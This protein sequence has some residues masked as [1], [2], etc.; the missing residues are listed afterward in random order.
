MHSMVFPLHLIA[1]LS[2]SIGCYAISSSEILSAHRYTE[3]YLPLTKSGS[4]S[5]W[6]DYVS[7]PSD[8][9]VATGLDTLDSR[10]KR[11]FLSR[12]S[13]SGS[14]FSHTTSCGSIQTGSSWKI[15]GTTD[16]LDSGSM[17]SDFCDCTSTP[18]CSISS[19]V[20]SSAFASTAEGSSPSKSATVTSLF[21]AVNASSVSQSAQIPS[22][23]T[24]SEAGASNSQSILTSSSKITRAKTTT[25]T[26]SSQYTQP[27][28]CTNTSQN[29]QWNITGYDLGCDESAN[30]VFLLP[31][32]SGTVS[33]ANVTEGFCNFE[34][35]M[36]SDEGPQ[37]RVYTFSHLNC[38][39]DEDSPLYVTEPGTTGCGGFTG[40]YYS[41]N[42]TLYNDD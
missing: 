33:C 5:I 10:V 36:N 12:N 40:L 24:V 3:T 39:Y 27:A 8:S 2:S 37:Y 15:S 31:S 29:S 23:I 11:H 14:Q 6:P 32:C 7:L 34:F 35:F 26:A 19:G 9:S 25:S 42:I 38:L 20:N 41:Y 28:N 13:L 17:V 18:A 21:P 30:I 4:V 16:V 22:T 1:A